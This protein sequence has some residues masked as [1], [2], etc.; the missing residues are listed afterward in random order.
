MSTTRVLLYCPKERFVDGGLPAE[1][2]VVTDTIPQHGQGPKNLHV[3]SVA[4]LIAKAITNLHESKSL[5]I[6]FDD[7]DLKSRG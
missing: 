2:I 3:V 4:P 7:L 6:L 5:S 1:K